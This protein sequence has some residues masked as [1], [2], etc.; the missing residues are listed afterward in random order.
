MSAARWMAACGLMLVSAV[1]VHGAGEEEPPFEAL[2]PQVV[3]GVESGCLARV[4]AEAP[5]EGLR[6]SVQDLDVMQPVAVK[7]IASDAAR[8]V[9]I[10][11][12]KGEWDSVHRHCAT[13]ES[14][15][16]EVRFRT[17]GNFGVRVAPVGGASAARFALGV[18]VG[19]EVQVVPDNL[20]T[21]AAA[22]RAWTTTDLLLAAVVV[23][24]GAGLA[25]G[26]VALRAHRR[27]AS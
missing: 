8:P 23:L 15:T 7:V 9:E 24:L 5:A 20:V 22:G 13:D 25:V 17:Q 3:E 12:V 14:G 11:I 16:C 2:Q 21:P 4:E 6:Y 19:E 1:G 18:W 10:Q 27:T 26:V